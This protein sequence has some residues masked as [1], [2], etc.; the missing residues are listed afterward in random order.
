MPFHGTLEG[1]RAAVAQLER[2]ATQP[3]DEL[4]LVDN[5]PDGRAGAAATDRVTVV[6]APREQTAYHARNAGAEHANCEWLLFT[7]ADCLLP[8]ALLDAYFAPHPADG[9]GAVVGGVVGARDQDG[10]IPRYVRSRRHLDQEAAFADTR[11]AYGVTA[12]LLVRR[13]AWQAV[14]GFYE[15]VQAGEDTGFCWRLQDAGRPLEL[16]LDAQVEHVHRHTLGGLLRQARRD[17]AGVAWLNRAYDRPHR[18]LRTPRRLVRA[19]AGVFL[20]VLALRFERALFKAID[21]LWFL[22][23]AVGM[24]ESNEPATPR[25]RAAADAVV[26]AAV[27]PRHGV[28]PAA[29]AVEALHRERL[30]DRGALAAAD[31]RY[32]EDDPPLR[33]VT[34]RVAL[35]LRCP[36][37]I[38]PVVRRVR[39]SKARR[40]IPYTDDDVQLARR[41]ARL[42]RARVELAGDVVRR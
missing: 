41:V 3:G 12:N 36:A 37:E 10:L 38:A 9:C 19:V 30:P 28:V 27:F 26:V 5:T 1:A 18:S 23:E 39:Q 25:D 42:S 7:D 33:R 34:T 35:G 31:P 8:P 11:G 6:S 24:L 32:A 15:R 21:A 17:A 22:A 29:L 4:V 13:S 40:V 16:R 20:W 2:L 14:G